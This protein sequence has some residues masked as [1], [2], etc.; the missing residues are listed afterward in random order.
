MENPQDPYNWD[1][2]DWDAVHGV[3]DRLGMYERLHLIRYIR[4][5]YCTRAVPEY[6]PDL[7]IAML[8]QMTEMER[9]AVC[10]YVNNFD[11]WLATALRERDRR[12]ANRPDG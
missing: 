9:E 2:V 5:T 1:A 10:T 6:D 7:A 4:A 11:E 12:R 3:F 8:D